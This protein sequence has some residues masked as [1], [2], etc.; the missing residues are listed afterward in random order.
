MATIECNDERPFRV[1]LPPYVVIF[2]SVLVLLV[3]PAGFITFFFIEVF[4]F[5]VREFVYDTPN[6]FRFIGQDIG[7]ATMALGI[8]KRECQPGCG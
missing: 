4:Q 6:I 3:R 7:D 2:A 1:A 5:A 8:L